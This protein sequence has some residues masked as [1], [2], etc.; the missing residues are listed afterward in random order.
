M[1][2]RIVIECDDYW[3]ANSLNALAAKVENT[4]ILAPVYNEAKTAKKKGDHYNAKIKYIEDK[5]S[6]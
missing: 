6:K 1:S 2:V 3:V 4:N 5:P